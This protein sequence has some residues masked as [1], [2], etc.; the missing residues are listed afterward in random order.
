MVNEY[1]RRWFGAFL[2]TV[3]EEWTRGEV[4]GIMK[5]LPL[6]DFVKL[7]DFCCGT[8][9]PVSRSGGDTVTASR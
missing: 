4:A 2:Q 8:T 1:S 3:P 6:P 5:R 9:V 7:L